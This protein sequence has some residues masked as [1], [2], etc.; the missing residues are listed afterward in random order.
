MMVM[1]IIDDDGDNSGDNGGDGGDDCDDDVIVDVF[2]DEFGDNDCFLTSFIFIGTKLD[3]ADLVIG[4]CKKLEVC[5]YKMQFG[6][7]LI[8]MII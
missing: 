5:L 8:N 1:M 7:L 4:L 6:Q 2:D 3:P